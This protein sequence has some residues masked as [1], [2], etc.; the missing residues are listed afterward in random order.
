MPEEERA[1]LVIESPDDA[2][3]VLRDIAEGTFNPD[4]Y[5]EIEFS[6][7]QCELVRIPGGV[8]S[9]ISMPMIRS[10]LDV[11][12]H[13]N[14]SY[15][16]I[17]F[18]DKIR[19]RIN[20]LERSEI[21]LNIV[22][23]PNGSV[24]GADA[25]KV[26]SAFAEAAVNRME[27]KHL[28][29]TLISAALIAAVGYFGNDSF[30]AYVAS[31]RAVSEAHERAD[32]M[33]K[34]S[35]QETARA[36]IMGALVAQNEESRRALVQ[37]EAGYQ[38]LLKGIAATGS[39]RVLGVDIPQDLAKDLAAKPRRSG[40]GGRLDGLYEVADVA[41]DGNGVFSVQLTGAGL[42]KPI[43]ADARPL[44]LP[45]DQIDSILASLKKGDQLSILLNVWKRGGA[46]V[47]AE[48]IRVSAAQ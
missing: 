21:E 33:I 11:Q 32:E 41:R 5:A 47:D 27:S 13:I 37:V 30:K 26:L 8:P 7:W 19:S 28:A 46:V 16:N 45:D 31:Q 34:L 25:R 29:I 3:V 2:W 4:D 44:F 42:S 14:K 22:V 20:N 38:A 24:Y 39:A 17:R 18:G 15:R 43:T 10:L 48:I 1:K 6:G 36:K 23:T 9:S 40:E 35:E 12:S